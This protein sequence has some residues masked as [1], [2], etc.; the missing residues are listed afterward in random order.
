MGIVI[1]KDTPTSP[2]FLATGI[3]GIISF[4]FTLGTF[5]KVVWVNLETLSE[6]PHEVHSYLT[7]LR[8]ELLEEKQSLKNMRKGMRKHR[9][10]Q[11]KEDGGSMVGMELDE[12]SLKT[13]NDAIRILIRRFRELEKPFLEPG[14]PGIGDAANHRKRA[15]RRNSSL[16][17]PHYDHAAYQSPPEKSVRARSRAR[18]NYD[19]DKEDYAED[20]VEDDAYWAQRVNYCRFTLGRDFCG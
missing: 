6:A 2:F 20:E 14:Q 10:M 4:G 13:M 18:S 3:I 16:S 8:T 9:K 7:N 19:R 12:V 15:R 1:S 11:R 17:P 5:F